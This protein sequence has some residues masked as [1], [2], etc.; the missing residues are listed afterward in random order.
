MKSSLTK[1]YIYNSILTILQLLF[2]LITF[3]YASRALGATGIGTVTFV[4]SIVSYFTV[5]ASLGIPNYGIREIAKFKD[6]HQNVSKIYSEIFAVNFTATV[7]SACVYY[8]LI[9]ILP[10]FQ[11]ERTLYIIIGFSVILNIFN[12]D[13]LFKGF[14]NYR[15]ITVR[16]VL[17]KLIS[18]AL[19]FL[20]VH[21][22]S[23]YVIYGAINVVALSGSNLVNAITARKYVKL[24]L[25]NIHIVSHLRPIFILFSSVVVINIYTNMDSTMLGIISGKIYVGYYAAANKIN[26][27]VLGIVTSLGA[28]LLPRLSYYIKHGYKE[29]FNALIK[30]SVR[31]VL[32][33]SIPACTG[34]F[35]LAPQ[36]I[37]VFSGSDFL[38]AILTMRIQILIILFVGLSNLTGIQI[39]LPLG[40]ENQ[41]LFSVIC[42]AIVDFC[43]N[44]ILIPLF[45]QNGAA[46]SS[47]IAELVVLLIQILFI[48]RY[49]KGKIINI[50]NLHYVIGSVFIYLAIFFIERLKLSDLITILLSVAISVFIYG[51]F[52]LMV[53]DPIVIE[54]LRKV[55]RKAGKKY[56]V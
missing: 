23:D 15:Y 1:N 32:L 30:K 53:R 44:L 38:P 5:I 22:K 28:V 11:S 27:A 18:I 13:W 29:K 26:G 42:G 9:F 39:L 7:T 8:L 49:M 37:R 43:L 46:L 34:L 4:T 14:E 20:L 50:R 21:N 19:L 2:P 31:F 10:V 35:V 54:G 24:D 33:I 56:E 52:N 51:I 12:V 16:S 17:F 40:R 3:P 45:Q 36:I 25:H 47:T 41:F 6:N 55:L 48:Y